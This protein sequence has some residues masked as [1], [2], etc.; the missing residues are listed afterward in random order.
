MKK[1]L[2]SVLL[3]ATAL[4]GID[5]HAATDKYE[6]DVFDLTLG[7]ALGVQPE[8]SGSDDR[9]AFVFPLIIAEYRFAEDQALFISPEAAIGYSYSFNDDVKAG[10]HIKHRSG[11]DSGEDRTLQ[12]MPDLDDTAEAGPFIEITKDDMTYTA[13]LR[14]DIGGVYDGFVADLGAEYKFKLSQK[15]H[16]TLGGNLSYGDD[17]F[18]QHYYGVKAGEANLAFNRPEYRASAG[19]YEVG[20]D[21]RLTYF[22]DKNLFFSLNIGVS[23]LLGDSNDSPVVQETTQAMGVFS[24]GYKLY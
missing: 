21:A 9:E 5:A 11:R 14:T 24:I 19:F 17:D 7:L 16:A 23:K 22:M 12:G 3:A 15:L 8:Y 20:A 2:S 13:S 1:I 4:V 10:L 6:N 18:A